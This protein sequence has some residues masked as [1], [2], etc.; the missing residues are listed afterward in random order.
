MTDWNGF[1]GPNAGYVE[2][3]YERFLRDPSSV[4]A[5]TR[6][7]FERHP[8]GVRPVPIA[9]DEDPADVRTLTAVVNLARSIREYGHL[10]AQIDP[11][12]SVPP[13]DPALDLEH[14]EI[15]ESDVA[16]LPASAIRLPEREGAGIHNALEAIQFL[17]DRYCGRSGYD[18]RQVRDPKERLWLREAIESRRFRPPNEAIDEVAL[19]HRLVEV[20][21]FERF[22]HRIFPG[23]TR[24]SIEGLDMLVPVLDEV[25]QRAGGAGTRNTLLGMA[26]RGR[27][28]VLAHVLCKPYEQILLEFKDPVQSRYF[29]EY[30]AWTGDV[31][32]H[33]G[34]RREIVDL[35]VTLAP[36][37]SHLEFVHPVV[38]GM[39]RAA[40]TSTDRPGSPPF[41]PDLTLPVVIHGDSAFA[42]QGI[43]PETLNF[44]RLEGYRTGGTIHIIANNQLGYTT[45]PDDSYG[46]LYCSDLAKGFKIPIVHVNADDPV[47]CIEAARMAF[48]YRSEFHKDFL[49]DLVGYRRHGHNEGDEPRFTQPMMYRK[50]TDHPSVLTQWAGHLG[51]DDDADDSLAALV[52]EQ[53]SKLES[54]LEKLD[55]G[56]RCEISVPDMPGDVK[57]ATV[58][59]AVERGRLEAMHDALLDVPPE[60][61]VNSKIRRSLDRRRKTFADFDKNSVDWAHAEAL[62]LGSILEDGI[63]IRFTGED[64]ER[65][66]F[67]QRHAVYHDAE[68]GKTYCP[69]ASLPGATASFE[70]HNS[71]LTEN[72]AVAFEYGYDVQQPGHFVLWEA[73]YGDFINGAQVILD[74]FVLS[75][76]AKW[77]QMPTMVLLLPH[78]YEGQGPDHCSGRPERFLSSAAENNV[79]IANCTKASQYFH[80]LRGHA[81]LLTTDPK[82]LVVL[83][84]KSLLRHPAV[85]SAPAELVEGSF[86]PL[87]VDELLERDPGGVRRLVFCSGKVAVDL[88]SSP[89]REECPDVAV[90]RIEQ[91]FPLPCADIEAAIAACTNLEEVVWL[92]EEPAN[93]GAWDFMR[94]RL[95]EILDGRVPLRY[96]GRPRRSSPAEGSAAWHA[97]NQEALVSHAFDRGRKLY[98]VDTAQSRGKRMK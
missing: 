2:E 75:G 4:D 44:S 32:Y 88:D 90:C 64:V 19:M 18:L 73:Q 78:G 6:A 98:E 23:K 52:R 16:A 94:P 28:N 60:F 54:E 72:A 39:A 89:R 49:I 91:L 96:L 30:D 12:G 21:C 26:H 82:P 79:R 63:P 53:M 50:I 45:T 74:E 10:G 61:A 71:P 29:S 85:A 55:A 1:V 81:S 68:S 20:E 62:A 76:R 25:I 13:G 35:H 24:F 47:A 57:L 58:E 80:L 33:M 83:T 66:T 56:D 95:K 42:G 9:K 51:K 14:Y 43:V 46:T 15:E 11:L 86:R 37:P 65:G 38:E 92:Q 84:P 67:S 93:M 22:L 77:N 8:Q 3:L 27:L 17:R 36:N 31:K 97:S 48:A 40:G 59:T 5:A 69:L 70:I 41:D 7:W 87:L 34:A